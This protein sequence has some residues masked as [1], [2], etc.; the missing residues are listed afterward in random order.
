MAPFV[1]GHDPDTGLFQDLL[2]IPFPELH[3]QVYLLDQTVDPVQAAVQLLEGFD[4]NLLRKSKGKILIADGVKEVGQFSVG[5]VHKNDQGMDLQ[6]K[7]QEKEA[8]QGI[9]FPGHTKGQGKGSPQDQ[10]H[11]KDKLEIKVATCHQFLFFNLL[12]RV[13]REMPNCWAAAL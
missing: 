6:P 5:T 10:K 4:G 3:L 1:I 13:C 9:F 7:K 12:Y 8:R 2:V 11:P